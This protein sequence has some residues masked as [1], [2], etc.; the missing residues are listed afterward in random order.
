MVRVKVHPAKYIRHYSPSISKN[1]WRECYYCHS[2]SRYIN[3][4]V[5]V[6][7]QKIKENPYYSHYT[8]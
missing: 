8:R 2:H 7:G 6:V 1:Q 5:R 3:P 4:Y